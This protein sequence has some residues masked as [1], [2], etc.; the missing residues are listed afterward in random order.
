MIRRALFTLALV[1]CGASPPPPEPPPGST[2]RPPIRITWRAEQGDGDLV[3]ITIVVEGKAVSLGSLPAATETEAGSPRTCAIRA[4]HPLR[5][6]FSCGDM[7][8]FYSAEL[9]GDELVLASVD[10]SGTHELQR[11]PVWGDGLAVTPYALP[12]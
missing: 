9:R 12:D 6:E 3:S 8:S 7:A 5:T 4:A 2:L 10:A 1:A 11:L